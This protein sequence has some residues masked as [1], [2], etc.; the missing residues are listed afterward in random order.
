[1]Q[2]DVRNIM[3]T[4]SAD[5]LDNLYRQFHKLKRNKWDP[6][7]PPVVEAYLFFAQMIRSYLDDD[8][9][10]LPFELLEL[11]AQHRAQNLIEA[12]IQQIQLVTIELDAEDDAQ[13]IFETLNARGVP[14]TPSDLVR[15]FIFLTATKQG[16]DVARLYNELWRTY[17]EDEPPN[18]P[19]WKQEERQGRLKRSRMD[20][21]LFHYVTFKTGEEL[22]IGHLYQAF[23]DWWESVPARSLE[24]ELRELQRYSEIYKV[25][26]APDVSTAFGRICSRLRVLDTTTAYPLLLWAAGELG[27]TSLAFIEM[28][29]DIESFIVRRVVCGYHQ[30]AYNRLFLETLGRLRR[31]GRVPDPQA[32]RE[33]L[34]GSPAESHVWPDDEEFVQHLRTDPI[35][36]TIG[37]RRT[38]ML[39]DALEHATP[40]A[41][42]EVITVHSSLSVEH[43]CPQT[44]SEE[45]WPLYIKDG[46][47]WA[48]AHLHRQN[49]V[50]HRLGNLTLLT[51]QLNAA[52]SNGPYRRKRPEIASQS[53]LA[54]NT[55]F[56]NVMEWDESQIEIRGQKLADIAVRIWPS[57]KGH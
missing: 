40:R 14:L 52:V 1:M 41:F 30:K 25:M 37:P 19:F 56:Q 12:L 17:E 32:L 9:D 49:V 2:N 5:A 11:S 29:T 6:P 8:P 39:L 3:L 47:G 50:A 53:A 4:D 33:S 18:K 42:G 51:Q 31:D 35:Y 55:Y 45:H 7:R 28:A 44:P 21:F 43:V 20:L 15:N 38:Q 46:E 26:L 10:E 13:V 48:D 34:A 54:L 27:T 57:P 23:R 24:V 22:K 36:K 16:Q